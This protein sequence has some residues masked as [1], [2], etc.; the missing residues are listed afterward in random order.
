MHGLQREIRIG[1]LRARDEEFD[2]TGTQRNCQLVVDRYRKP[3]D[4]INV[5]F[6][7]LERFLASG[8]E[9]HLRRGGAHRF[10]ELG[11]EM[12]QMLAIVEH[13]QQSL[14]REQ[15][16]NAGRGRLVA[17]KV[18]AQRAGHGRRYESAVRMSFGRATD[19][20]SAA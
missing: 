13:Q 4:A 8:K 3:A 12:D 18:H 15:R 20:L 9:A 16:R 7:N 10:D 14:R 1:L 5:L 6:R 17:R 19:E 11:D 2:G